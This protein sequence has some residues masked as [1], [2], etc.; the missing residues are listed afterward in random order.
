[1][2]IFSNTGKATISIIIA[3]V[4]FSCSNDIK[5]VN[6]VT[7]KEDFP[8]LWAK[9]VSFIYTDS[10]LVKANITASEIKRFNSIEKPYMEFPQGLMIVYF[11]KY[12]DTNSRISS[13]YAIR[14][15]K[16]RK[17]EAKGDVVVKNT[18]GDVLNTEYMVWDESKEIIYSDKFV[19]ISTGTDV[20]IGEGFEADQTFERWK[21]L[22]VKGT[23]SIDENNQNG[24]GTN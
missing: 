14:W 12:P 10:G 13:N 21:I 8:D 19:K 20:I 23:I 4:A 24:N 15:I 2:Q 16:D 6:L 5:T 1:M 3:L 22:K 17:W 7:R 11:K 9:K 18:K